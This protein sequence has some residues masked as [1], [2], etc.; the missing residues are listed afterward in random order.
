MAHE[1]IAPSLEWQA[2]IGVAIRSMQ[3]M[4]AL[5]TKEF[6]RSKWTDQ[7]VGMA[8]ARGVLVVPI[9]LGMGP[10]GFMAK[11]QALPG[12]LAKPKELAAAIAAVLARNP[13]TSDLMT[14]ALVAAL[15]AANSYLAAIAAASAIDKAPRFTKSQLSRLEASVTANSQVRDAFGVP[16]KIARVVA[17]HR[18]GSGR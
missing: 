11:N 13:S 7:E 2:E 1:D 9:R 6:H 12:D 14:E 10:Y 8:I 17:R 5:L 18:S 16:T 3:A 4:A 15:E